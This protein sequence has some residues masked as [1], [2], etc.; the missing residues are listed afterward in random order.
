MNWLQKISQVNNLEQMLIEVAQGVRDINQVAQYVSRLAPA[1]PDV[2]AMI[3]NIGGMYPGSNSSMGRIARAAGCQFNPNAEQNGNE[4]E[5][6]MGN[7]TPTL[8]TEN[9]MEMP[10]I[11]IE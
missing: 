6:E 1:P 8:P 2:C 10:T 3:S 9:S 4:N 7:V 11:A 5:N